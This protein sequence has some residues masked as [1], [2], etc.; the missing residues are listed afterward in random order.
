MPTMIRDQGGAILATV[1]PPSTPAV[2]SDTALVVAQNA[3]TSSTKIGDGNNNAAVKAASTP[4]AATD[5]S[6]VVAIHPLSN[7]AVPYNTT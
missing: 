7:S 5:P 6:L 2:A 4:A 3:A 1:K